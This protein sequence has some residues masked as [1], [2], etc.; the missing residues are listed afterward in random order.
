MDQIEL[1]H[2]SWEAAEEMTRQ[3]NVMQSRNYYD[4]LHDVKL[5]QRQMEYLGF[6]DPS[7]ARFALNYCRV[8]ID[9][10]VERLLVSGFTTTAGEDEDD[11]LAQW[12]WETWQQNRMDEKQSNV[13]RGAE[14][15][16]EFFVIVDWD[17]DKARPR[18]TPHRRYT[19][20]S[21]D[22][23]GFGCKG[24]YP[25]DDPDQEMEYASKRWTE[26]FYDEKGERRT[27]QRMN[28]YYPN[29]VERWIKAGKG[30]TSEATW[31]EYELDGLS[32]LLPW[33]VGGITP[34]AYD[35]R[36]VWQ[37]SG[38]EPLGIPVVHFKAPEIKSGLW[39]AIPIQDGIN[40]T[41]LDLLAIADSCGFR[42]MLTIGFTPTTD[43]EE[44]ESDG[45]NYIKLF[46]GALIYVPEDG[47]IKPIE[48]ADLKPLLILLDSLIIKLA[49]V[50]DT[51]ISRFQ[52]SRQ[53]A[54]E[55]T[56]KQQEEPL[57]AKVRARHVI[58]GNDWED[59]FDMARRLAK[60]KGQILNV[61]AVLNTQWMP[62]EPRDEKEEIETIG[63]KVEKLGIPLETAW[64][65][66]GYTA[67]EIEDMKET[68]EWKSRQAMQGMALEMASGGEG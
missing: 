43:G 48:G 12:M 62:A 27:R 40:K 47:D 46:P 15:E 51:P 31:V 65:E 4:G 67:D 59:C 34:G 7:A 6:K 41:A 45:S 37:D 50:T 26:A 54:A 8:V 23:D 57:I 44:P 19:D 39:D 61:D 32:W 2:A 16:G 42:I 24:H 21:V 11:K 60:E 14:R 9:S 52:V 56:L 3:K 17:E 5:S 35:E 63:L 49:Q 13:H 29:R 30:R 10:V 55:G 1:A 33:T 66:A 58:Y 53:I 18:F 25:D 28:L 36:K 20:P 38:A 22:G 68:E 64:K